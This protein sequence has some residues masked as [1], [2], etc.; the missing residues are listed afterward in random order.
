[1]HAQWKSDWCIKCSISSLDCLSLKMEISYKIIYYMHTWDCTALPKIESTYNGCFTTSKCQSLSLD[2]NQEVPQNVFFEKKTVQTLYSF[3]VSPQDSFGRPEAAGSHCRCQSETVSL[4]WMMLKI[5]W[6]V[7]PREGLA[8][9]D[10]G[11]PQ[12][13]S[14]LWKA[15]WTDTISGKKF[16]QHIIRDFHREINYIGS[17]NSEM[18]SE[19]RKG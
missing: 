15:V 12:N 14:Y 11:F 6:M 8:I 10:S 18:S 1:M 3:P 4:N 2:L 7:V 19:Y 9:K 16:W 17:W 5:K 13:Y